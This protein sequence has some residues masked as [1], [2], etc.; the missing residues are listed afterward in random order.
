MTPG[1]IRAA[2]EADLEAFI[3]LVAPYLELGDEH[4]SLIQWWTSSQ[5]KN[6]VLVLLPR[7]HLK[8]RLV[9]LKTAWEITRDPTETI[10]YVSATIDLAK[11]QVNLVKQILTSEVYRR[12][13][14]EMVSAEPGFRELWTDEEIAVD[15]PMRKAAGVRDPTLKAAGLRK[16]ITGFHATKMKLDDIVV[17]GNAYTEDGRTRVRNA[18]S[19]FASILEPDASIDAV[20][21]RYHPKDQYSTFLSQ[22]YEVYDEEGQLVEEVYLWDSY[23]R[24]VE[25]GGV[26]LWP[27][28][29]RESDGKYFGFDATVL[30]KIRASYED[31]EQFY[32]QYYND[33]NNPGLARIDRSKFQYY[34]RARLVEEDG[35]WYIGDEPLAVYAGMDLAYSLTKKADFSALVVIGITPRNHIYIMDIVRFKTDR[36]GRYFDSVRNAYEKWGFR[37]IR[38]EATAA[39]KV[40]VRDLKE[41][42]I[43]PNGMALSVDEYS[44][45]RHTGT[46][47][48][49]ISAT[50][51]P[52]YDNMQ[53]WHYKGGEIAMLEDELVMTRP[54]HDDIKDGLTAAIDIAV[55]PR[56]ARARSSTPKQRVTFNTRFGGVQY[57]K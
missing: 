3:A 10:L 16:N 54:P 35:R 9:A 33:P 32:A 29:R 41:N 13:W 24:V 8:S 6:N 53:V 48:E 5:R 7:G 57:R 18:V 55:P 47:D 39:Q 51:E 40:I 56:S 45:T 19:Q 50:L 12:Y 42:Y 11:K 46:K 17:P 22:S 36:I 44:P 26:F 52:K 37:K 14:P 23:T 38:I 25:V 28:K 43:V 20:G 1:E 4:R 21:T 49:R 15:H 27:R 30:A 34:D 2:A 31:R